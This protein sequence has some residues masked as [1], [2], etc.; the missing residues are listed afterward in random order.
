MT[1]IYQNTDIPIQVRVAEILKTDE[2]FGFS[3]RK[4]FTV[5]SLMVNGYAVGIDD[6]GNPALHPGDFP[7]FKRSQP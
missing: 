4:S 6:K 1:E 7:D 2:N 5:A 3:F